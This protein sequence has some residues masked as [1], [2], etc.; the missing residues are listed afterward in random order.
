MTHYI[1]T[2]SLTVLF[3]AI[4][5]SELYV[6]CIKQM[7]LLHSVYI[8]FLFI[9][10]SPSR[11]QSEWWLSNGTCTFPIHLEENREDALLPSHPLFMLQ[12]RVINFFHKIFWVFLCLGQKA[13]TLKTTNVSSNWPCWHQSLWSG[14]H[15]YPE[16]GDFLSFY[17]I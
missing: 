4:I 17:I 10:P 9:V 1:P 12:S 13:F 3:L 15:G 5:T 6:H 8:P 2:H 14:S 16:V 7:A 11:K